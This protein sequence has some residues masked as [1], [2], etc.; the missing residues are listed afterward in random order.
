MDRERIVADLRKE[1]D[2]TRSE[3]GFTAT[4]EELDKIFFITD[5]VLEAGFVSFNFS[6]Q[7]C[8]RIVDLF[9]GW[10]NYLHGLIMPNPSYLINIAESNTLNDSERKEINKLISETMVLVSSNTLVGL[11]GDKK[12]EARLI[13]ESVRFWNN[14]YKPKLINIMSKIQENWRK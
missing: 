3:L 2:K 7:L 13:D 12:E 11:T 8:H 14:V 9:A 4:L 10:N 1:F 5:Y 6:R